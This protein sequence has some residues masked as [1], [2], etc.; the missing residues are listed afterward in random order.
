LAKR[1]NVA[2]NDIKKVFVAGAFGTY[3]DPQS[4]RTI[5]MYPGLPLGRISFAGNTAGSGARMALLSKD[6]R[7]EA[8]KIAENLKYIELAADPDFRQE[9]ADA[10]YIPHRNANLFPT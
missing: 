7:I 2:I 5:G 1:L 9:F 6:Q 8:Q 4:A 3:V 10:L